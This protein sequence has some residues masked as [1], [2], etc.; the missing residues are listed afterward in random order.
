M[1][2]Y[3]VT[4]NFDDIRSCGLLPKMCKDWDSRSEDLTDNEKLVSY[5]NDNIQKLLQKTK[6]IIYGDLQDTSIV[7]SADEEA[8]SY[9]KEIFKELELISMEY[10]DIMRCENCIKHDYLE[11]R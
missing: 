3:G 9:I 2:L 10:E 1:K 4:L 5:W 8:I 7:F 6:N 11:N